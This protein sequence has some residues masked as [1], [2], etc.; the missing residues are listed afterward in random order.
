MLKPLA[1]WII[2]NLSPEKWVKKQ[3]L[4]SCMEQLTGSGLRKEYNRAV[5]CHPVYLTYTQ[6]TCEIL[7]WMSYKLESRLRI[8]TT[9]DNVD[10]TTLIAE[11]EKELESL[12]MRGVG[13]K[14]KSWLKTQYRKTKIMASGPITSQIEGEKVAAVT[15]F[16]F[17]VS[18]IWW[19]VTAAMKLEDDCFLARKLWQT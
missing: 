7:G 19:M 17:L 18:K 1:M 8:S 9:S 2:T 16:I 12:L 13:G 15:D 11:S 4:E 3:Q 10:D 5:D 14:W 6:N